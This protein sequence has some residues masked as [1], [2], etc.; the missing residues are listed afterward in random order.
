MDAN[1]TGRAE[2]FEV[3]KVEP[4]WT[5]GVTVLVMHLGGERRGLAPLARRLLS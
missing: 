4:P 5:A 2:S 3:R 1:M